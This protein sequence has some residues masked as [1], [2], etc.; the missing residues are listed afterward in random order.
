MKA[1]NTSADPSDNKPSDHSEKSISDSNKQLP[2][3]F[4][5]F[6]DF[7]DRYDLRECQHELWRL[8]SAAIASEDADQWDR[9][10]R[11]NVVFFCGNLDKLLKAM[12]DFREQLIKE[13]QGP[14]KSI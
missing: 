3:P 9:H 5:V 6:N 8:L 13:N 12:F 11:G 4:Q 7:F 2:E 10:D 14:P 1:G